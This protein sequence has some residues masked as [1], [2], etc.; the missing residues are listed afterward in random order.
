MFILKE[1]G[2]SL[3]LH[4]KTKDGDKTQYCPFAPGEDFCGDWCPLF[5]WEPQKVVA[6]EKRATL[7]LACSGIRITLYVEME[8]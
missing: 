3:S 6:E 8:T 4:R 5:Q 2:T 1:I 7:I